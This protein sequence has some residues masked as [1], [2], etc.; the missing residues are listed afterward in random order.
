MNARHG[1]V[2]VIDDDTSVRKS[3]QRLL[4]S[5]HYESETFV[6][7][8]AFLER[9]SHPGPS[10]LVVDVQMPGLNG[11]ELQEALLQRRREEQLV[12]LTGHGDIP[13]CARVM[14][15]GGRWISCQPFKP[16]EL[17]PCVERA[18]G[19]SQK[20]QSKSTAASS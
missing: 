8:D 13:M 2:F 12:F 16:G 17:L 11:I 9:S 15:A 3:L 14:K 20:Q 4:N 7:A 19:R 18:P 10:C 5:A 1:M 6:S